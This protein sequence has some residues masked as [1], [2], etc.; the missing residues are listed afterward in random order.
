MIQEELSLVDKAVEI[1]MNEL[2]AGR[3][4][5]HSFEEIKKSITRKL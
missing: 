4:A 2:H 3:A 5:T 1:E